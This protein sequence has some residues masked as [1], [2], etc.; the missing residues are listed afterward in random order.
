ML[1]LFEEKMER[2]EKRSGVIDTSNAPSGSDAEDA[3]MLGLT[4]RQLPHLR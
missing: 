1:D 2:L 4:R 3:S